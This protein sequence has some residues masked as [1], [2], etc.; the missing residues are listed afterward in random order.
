MSV[1]LFQLLRQGT[2][3]SLLRL[4]LNPVAFTLPLYPSLFLSPLTLTCVDVSVVP[5]RT[6]T[7]VWHLSYSMLP[8][9]ILSLCLT[10]VL[11]IYLSVRPSI[12]LSLYLSCMFM[13]VWCRA[14]HM[15]KA[16]PYIILICFMIQSHIS[17]G[18]V[19]E[20]IVGSGVFLSFGVLSGD[21]FPA[22]DCREV[23]KNSFKQSLPT[24]WGISM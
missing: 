13:R 3:V 24:I 23:K 15:Y 5:L 10:I 19:L 2:R 16:A 21:S 14:L 18:F 20:S 7:H 17:Y 1:C 9:H 11:L 6:I 22:P 12:C 8:C 4:L